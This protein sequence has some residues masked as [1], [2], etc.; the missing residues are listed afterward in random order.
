MDDLKRAVLLPCVDMFVGLPVFPCSM[1]CGDDPYCPV[2][3]LHLYYFQQCLQCLQ[4]VPAIKT[5]QAYPASSAG[6]E[7]HNGRSGGRIAPQNALGPKPVA[8]ALTQHGIP[9]RR[10]NS[11]NHPSDHQQQPRLPSLGQVMPW[12]PL[13]RS[14][15]LFQ[16][17]NT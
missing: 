17:N 12:Q 7:Q 11:A 2:F 10:Q 4:W 6:I 15:R 1:M 14:P 5:S 16:P 13:H 9:P 3:S 8:A